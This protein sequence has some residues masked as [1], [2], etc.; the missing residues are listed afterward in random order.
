MAPMPTTTLIVKG[1]ADHLI[2]NPKY[3]YVVKKSARSYLLYLLTSYVLAERVEYERY[4]CKHVIGN[5]CAGRVV[6]KL[7]EM[8]I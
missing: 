6:L 2:Q 4:F 8:A 3:Y 7:R 1:I 5:L